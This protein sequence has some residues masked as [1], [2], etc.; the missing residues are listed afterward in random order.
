MKDAFIRKRLA[1]L[2]DAVGIPAEQAAAAALARPELLQRPLTAW[3]A[4]RRWLKQHLPPEERSALARQ[5]PGD[6]AA[7]LLGL[8]DAMRVLRQWTQVQGS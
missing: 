3:V 8:Q 6:L 1:A 5:T 7:S 2:Q 4:A